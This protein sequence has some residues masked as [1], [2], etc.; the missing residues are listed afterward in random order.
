MTIP[1]EDF[2][3]LPLTNLMI[4][5][6]CC[7][8]FSG[9]W[10]FAIPLTVECSSSGSSFHGNSQ[11][12]ILERAAIPF[13]RVSFPIQGLKVHLPHCRWILPW[14]TREARWLHDPT[15][16]SV[17]FSSV[18]QLCPTLCDPMNCSKQDFPVHHQLPEFT[19]THVHWVGDVIQPSH[20]LLS[21]SP[22]AFNLT[23]HQG[24]FKISQF[25]AS[26]GQS[27]AVSA[28]ASVLLM[29][30]QDWFSLG[31]TGWISLQSK[32]LSRVSPNTTVQKHQ[33]FGTQLSL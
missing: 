25:F 2:A 14:A 12:R 33:F 6:C 11:A 30:I 18:T 5:S 20:T 3:I 26:G 7:Y 32:G 29:N 31:W 24:L 23:Q 21:S 13:F 4:A 27:I 15:F 10:L 9:V 19:Q 1:K 17:Q 16:S 8:S 22:P 28:S